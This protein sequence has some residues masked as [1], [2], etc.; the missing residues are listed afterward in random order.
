[1]PSNRIYLGIDTHSNLA[2][3]LEPAGDAVYF[4]TVSAGARGEDLCKFVCAEED[5]F[6]ATHSRS[7]QITG[8]AGNCSIHPAG[9]EVVI[10]FQR[11]EDPEPSSCTLSTNSFQRVLNLVRNR[12]Y[13]T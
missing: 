5:L 6:A 12:A 8:H 10:E 13:L 3:S 2:I 4:L 11:V 7:V 1:V 9:D